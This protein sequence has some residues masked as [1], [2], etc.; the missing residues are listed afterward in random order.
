M[1][2]AT[3]EDQNEER[4]GLLAGLFGRVTDVSVQPPFFCDYGKNIV[5]G[6]NV[7]FNFNCVVL[8]VALVTIG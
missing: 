8:D 5:L 4:K 6:K 2:N 1:L 7:F 3:R